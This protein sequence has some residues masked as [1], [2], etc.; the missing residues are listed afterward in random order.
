MN[1][2][3]SGNIKIGETIYT[4]AH[5]QLLSKDGVQRLVHLERELKR[6]SLAAVYEGELRIAASASELDND[7][8][9]RI[10][11][12][13][14]TSQEGFLASVVAR[15][16]ELT[17]A[18][19][20]PGDRRHWENLIAPLGGSTNLQEFLE[21]ELASER[22]R[23]IVA[24]PVRAMRTLSLSFCAPNLVPL[25]AFRELAADYVL[26]AI[27]GV[28]DSP[29]HF[30]LVGAFEVCADWLAR[31]AR[32]EELGSK[33][34]ERLLGDMDTLKRACTMYASGLLMAVPRLLQHSEYR[35]M[36]AFWRRLAA[37]TQASLIVRACSSDGADTVL[38]WA[39]EQFGKSFFF[40]V[41]LDEAEESRW[42]PDW[43]TPKFLVADAFGRIDFVVHNLPGST[44]PPGWSAQLEKA[45]E[46]IS[47]AKIAASCFFPAVGESARRK[48]P[49]IADTLAHRPMFEEFCA[50]PS[51]ESLFGC[52][53]SIFIA[54]VPPEIVGHC[55]EILSGLK[56]GVARWDDGTT[57]PV[58]QILSFVALQARDVGMADAVVEFCIELSRECPADGS[59]SE[60]I[61]RLLECAAANPDRR[62]AIQTFAR[63]LERVAFLALP[64]TLNDLHASIA[65]LQSLD[66]SLSIELG[67]AVAIARLGRRAA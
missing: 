34:L 3:G 28:V 39:I 47:E 65:V 24:D 9:L 1:P 67:K 36:P 51:A 6:H 60:I 31:D 7:Q 66:D 4:F 45:R 20:L 30:A 14:G 54:G 42:R 55:K 12:A 57:A 25:A 53:I 27:E 13:L 29:D 56:E 49:M 62:A 64:P 41:L 16:Q 23:R 52:A 8:F 48:Q 5:I 40:A 11:G 19:L 43:V 17:N 10:V 22:G 21:N 46:W 15:G 35:H 50:A 63:R 33:I 44:R 32:F 2:N 18:D 58:L 38:K 59:Q 61:C 37:A 26:K